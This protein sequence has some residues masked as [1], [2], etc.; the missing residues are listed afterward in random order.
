MTER[1]CGDC[2]F[3]KV[4]ES[5]ED[6]DVGR[7]KLEKLMGVFRDTTR[8]CP[9][10]SRPGDTHLPSASSSARTGGARSPADPIRFN[11]SS[12]ALAEL[13]G[14]T[15][16]TELK[17]ALSDLIKD[18]VALPRHPLP[19][20]I[21]GDVCIIP[22]DTTLKS[23]DIPFDQFVNKAFMLRDNLRVLEQKVNGN[24]K[25]GMSLRLEL[26][27]RVSAC[28]AAVLDLASGWHLPDGQPGE[29]GSLLASLN[30]DVRWNSL[31]LAAPSI[32]D[33]WRGG[34]VTYG[35]TGMAEPVEHL[36]FRLAVVR[37]QL[38]S[39]EATIDAMLQLTKEE[40]DLLTGYLKRCH[41]TMTTFNIM[42]RDRTDYFSS[43]R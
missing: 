28:Q 15:A 23:K 43:S 9:S 17:S 30:R 32:G 20:R 36:F 25:F 35:D 26:Q 16:P 3:F 41:G 1:T 7:C 40:R 19:T 8:A 33:R 24:D 13:L 42:F 2:R 39:L 22:A 5:R 12:G 10:F 4:T 6:S 14:T 11:V 37:D 31:I 29:A 34:R 18:C 38:L 21:E 27:G